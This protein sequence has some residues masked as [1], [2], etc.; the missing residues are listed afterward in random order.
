MIVEIETGLPKPPPG[1]QTVRN[2][3]ADDRDTYLRLARHAETGANISEWLSSA[4][5]Q[6][7]K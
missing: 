1:H 4:G 3:R 7:P 6:S 5:L 2:M